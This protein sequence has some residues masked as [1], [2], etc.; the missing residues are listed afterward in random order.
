VAARAQRDRLCTPL[1]ERE[2]DAAAAREARLEAALGPS[3]A[4][5]AIATG[6]RLDL[7]GAADLTATLADAAAM[8]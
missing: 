8:G 7:G 1:V 2:R 3:A 5:R 6:L 4:E